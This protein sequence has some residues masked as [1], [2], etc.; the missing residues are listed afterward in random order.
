MVDVLGIA[1]V[2]GGLVLL[3]AGAALSIY[4]VAILGVIVG[5]GV[6]FLFAPTI[7]QA[8]GLSDLLAV[9]AATAI[10]IVVGLV[11]TYLLLSMAIGMLGFVAGTYAGLVVL[12][13]VLADGSAVFVYPAAILVGIVAAV[14][15]TI[16]T[17]TVMV[18]VTSFAGAALA[19]GSVTISD[20]EAAGDSLALDPLLFDFASPI[21]LGLFVLG[22]LTQFGLF[23]F[24]YVTKL[25]SYL[26]GASVFTDSRQESGS[27]ESDAR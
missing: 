12:T 22:V 8:I 19:S 2:I 5:G 7:G 26:P 11:V 18:L 4:G 21:L 14:L 23:S 10:G 17:K 16:L 9:V 13:P 1:V 25:V 3:F 27:T 20:V 15:G 6:G 24:G